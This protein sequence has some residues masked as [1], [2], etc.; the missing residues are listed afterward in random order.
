MVSYGLA[1]SIRM[2]TWRLFGLVFGKRE[3][4]EQQVC[5]VAV[6]PTAGTTTV[7]A[8]ARRASTAA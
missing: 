5:L 6:V 4:G 1:S 8:V 7:A 3:V 2:R